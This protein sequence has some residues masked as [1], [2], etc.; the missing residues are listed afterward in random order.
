[1]RNEEVSVAPTVR[2]ARGGCW[3]TLCSRCIVCVRANVLWLITACSA[4][5]GCCRH[6]VTDRSPPQTQ[7]LYNSSRMCMFSLYVYVLVNC[8][9]YAT[10]ICR[11]MLPVD[12]IAATNCQQ[13]FF[14]WTHCRGK[15]AVCCRSELVSVVKAADPP[16]ICM[17]YLTH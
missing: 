15:R 14:A 5:S 12:A 6:T 17:G 1:M 9:R 13:A 11:Y 10:C 16:G 7:L 8:K 3:L 4:Y 2:P